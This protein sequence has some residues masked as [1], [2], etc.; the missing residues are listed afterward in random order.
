MVIEIDIRRF[1]PVAVPFEDESPLLVDA[2]RMK[3][4]Q[5]AAQFLKMIARRYA[6]VLIGTSVVDHL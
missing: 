1:A 2:D 4:D 6:Q 5:L 3:I